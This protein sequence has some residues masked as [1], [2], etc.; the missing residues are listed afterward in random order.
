MN[1]QTRAEGKDFARFIAS[2][3]QSD[4][5][6]G[7]QIQRQQVEQDY[8]EFLVQFKKG[9]CYLCNKPLKSFSKKSPCVHWLLKPN[10]FKKNDLP[11][12]A[13]L[14]GFS[15]LQGFLRWVA[16]QDG[17]ARN[18]NDLP[19][20]GSSSKLFEVTIKYKNLDWAFSCAESDYLGHATSQNAKYPHY[21]FQMRVDKRSFIN[22]N[23]F[24]VPFSE[25]DIIEIEAK[26]S[27]PIKIKQQHLFGEGM[28]DVL[29]DATVEHIVRNSIPTKA[30]DKAD[31]EIDIVVIAQEGETINGDD[32]N[33]I[34]QEA[35]ENNVTIA[36]LIHKL[37]SSN[38]QVI[39]TAGTH[40]V[41]QTPRSGR[42][43]DAKPKD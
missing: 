29:N 2:L 21:H 5:T 24:H 40:V 31:F 14:Y 35:K 16:N 42:K 34:T 18:I 41:K 8:K 37:P 11:A 39:V 38:T 30:R 6:K 27:L 28:H 26:R 17:F 23:D 15:Q 43:K 1:E 19:E 22:Y 4:I 3:S 25:M 33:K 7:N 32:L 36:S 13:K 9:N 10:G 12:I 20:E